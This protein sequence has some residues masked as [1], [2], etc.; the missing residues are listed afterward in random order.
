VDFA[1]GNN[2]RDA[3]DGQPDRG[4]AQPTPGEPLAVTEARRRDVD[5]RVGGQDP[6]SSAGS[7]ATA[8]MARSVDP[9][10]AVTTRSTAVAAWP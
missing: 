7:A 9:T 4:E 6:A 3:V 2:P 8:A 5:A 10:A 1:E